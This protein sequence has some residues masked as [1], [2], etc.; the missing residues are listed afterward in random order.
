MATP[1]KTYVICATP[2]CGSHFLGEALASTGLAG[3]PD[4]Y[5]QPNPDGTLQNEKGNIASQHGARPLMPFRDFVIDR[6]QSPNGVAG[7]SIHGNYL[8][9]VIE[10]YQTLPEFEQ[11][12]RFELLNALL[13]NPQFIWIK[14]R[15]KVRQAV[16]WVKA[17]QSGVWGEF[18]DGNTIGKGVAQFNYDY[19]LIDQNI[20]S[21]Y[22]FE[23]RW[24]EFFDENNIEPYVVVYEDLTKDIDGAVLKI[25]DFLEIDYSEDIQF[26]ERKH[27]KQANE[28]SEKWVKKYLR[29]RDSFAHQVF[30]YLRWIRFRMF[31][32]WVRK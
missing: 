15:D 7:V 32:N 2:R 17:K 13:Y 4:E 31:P 1:Q 14:R 26:A 8:H 30:R 9:Q 29:Q 10:N 18:K 20:N 11:M 12:N 24:Q 3:H 5:F 22:E 23:A 16:S 19:F 27:K 25:L 21:F 6:A 28:L